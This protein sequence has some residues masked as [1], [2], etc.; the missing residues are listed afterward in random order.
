[1]RFLEKKHTERIMQNKKKLLF[2]LLF[3]F[4]VAGITMY[5]IFQGKDL[6]TICEYVRKA[7]P[8]FIL[9]SFLCVI[10]FIWGESNIIFTMLRSWG[11]RVS[12]R[13]CYLYSC[14]GFFFSCITP[15]ASGGQPA[16][17][18]Y[19]KKDNIPIPVSTVILMVITIAYKMVLVVVGTLILLF[20]PK[21]L[22][23]RL[24][25]VMFW[26]YLGVALNIFCVT[27][28]CFLVFHPSLAKRI[29]LFLLDRME[30]W[31]LL[32]KKAQRREKLENAMELYQETAAYLAQHKGMVFYSFIISLLQR[33]AL[34]FVTSLTYLAFGLRGES[35]IELLLL[36]AMISVS[37]DMLPLPGGMGISEQLFLSIF[38]PVFGSQLTLPAMLVSRGIS[39][40]GQ[41]LISAVLTVYAGFRIGKKGKME[42]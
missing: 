32:R 15:S 29:M 40:Y 22:M 5:C 38:L 27:L 39:Y 8:K 30:R 31:H 4:L 37:V 1:M 21:G 6:A 35:L 28:M 23:E 14:I 41:L 19:M 42:D 25:P 36:Q 26:C 2:Q 24:S 10:V 16:Q 7:E 34:F 3:L 9:L 11:E 20:R 17:I 33:I 13:R 18:Y 12:A